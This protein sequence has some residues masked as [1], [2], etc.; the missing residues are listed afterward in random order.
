MKKP[1]TIVIFNPFTGKLD[2]VNKSTSKSDIVKM[3]L[4]D[5]RQDIEFHVSSLLFD[6]DSV[7]YND[8]DA[9]AIDD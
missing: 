7:L 5:S 6:E 4:I 1:N 2:Y 3:F 8:D 9:G